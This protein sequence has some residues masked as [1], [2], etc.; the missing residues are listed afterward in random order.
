M[1]RHIAVLGFVL[2]GTAA[3]C[4][5]AQPPAPAAEVPSYVVFF[6]PWSADLDQPAQGVVSDAARAA[7]AAP[8]RP[9]LVEGYADYT[10]GS[11]QANSTLT[12]LR[13]EHVADGLVERG[14]SRNRIQLRPR[15][16]TAGQDAGV[17][18]RRV[19]IEIG[20]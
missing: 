11:Q 17:E 7:Q 19:V 14:V 15:G 3:A 1:R 18:S 2:A 12:R 10:V 16:M 20:T 6:T 4:A 9:V 8:G 5:P 13:A